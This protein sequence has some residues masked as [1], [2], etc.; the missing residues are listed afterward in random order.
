MPT[1][2]VSILRHLDFITR[3]G[4]T[5]AH[6]GAALYRTAQDLPIHATKAFMEEA[7]SEF[8]RIKGLKEELKVK[9]AEL[10]K[11]LKGKKA[12]A[13]SL[14]AAVQLA[15]DTAL[16]HKDSYVTTYR[17]MMELRGSL[18]SVRADYTKLQ[19]HLV[20]SVTVAYEN[21]KEQV[22]VFTPD[23]DLSLF[24]LDNIVR[25]G[26]IVPDDLMMMM[27]IVLHCLLLR[28]LLRRPL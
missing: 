1:D 12:R 21:L 16:K 18:E 27:M 19:S 4:I 17:E 25:D 2:D 11:K 22:R 6:M 10:E 20:G 28:P 3:S 14:V 15:E 9:V 26:K 13:I 5:L 8:D 7:K 23:L 24:S